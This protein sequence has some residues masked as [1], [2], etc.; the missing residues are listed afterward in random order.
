MQSIRKEIVPFPGGVNAQFGRDSNEREETRLLG[1]I[2]RGD[3]LALKELYDRRG[4]AIFSMLLR[5]LTDEME[6]QECLQD[7]F[8]TIWRRAAE[9]DSDRSSPLTWMVMIARGRAWDRLRT[10]A[11]RSATQAEYEREIASL[12]V[13]FNDPA[14]ERIERDEIS[15]ECARALNDLPEEQSRALQLAFF[16]GWTHEEIARAVG[17]PLGTI[18]ARIRRGLLALRRKLKDRNG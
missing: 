11:R 2:G 18:K 14:N 15:S 9:F 4:G 8:V 13:E 1:A 5:M 10:R 16:R 7:V 6:A 12:E 17:E 3:S